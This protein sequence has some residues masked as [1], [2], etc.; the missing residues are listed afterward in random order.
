MCKNKRVVPLL[1]CS[2]KDNHTIFILH[3]TYRLLDYTDQ[4][5]SL[6]M[7]LPVKAMHI[8]NIKCS[9]YLIIK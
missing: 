4:Q 8:C 9:V 3:L 1:F 7:E 6:Q 2:V 5:C